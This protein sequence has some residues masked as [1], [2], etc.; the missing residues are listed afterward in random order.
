M[1]LTETQLMKPTSSHV[2]TWFEKF[3]LTIHRSRHKTSF[4]FCIQQH[5]IWCPEAAV[6]FLFH[7]YC[8]H[9]Q[10]NTL[11]SEGSTLNGHLNPGLLLVALLPARRRVSHMFFCQYRKKN[12]FFQV[13]EIGWMI[14]VQIW[15][16]SSFITTL[17]FPSFVDSWV[18]RDQPAT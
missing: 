5:K 16:T 6:N 8:F 4:Q 13:A 12:M 2:E 14:H 7:F 3:L 9:H 1:L 17:F 10:W 15:S 11:R 18:S